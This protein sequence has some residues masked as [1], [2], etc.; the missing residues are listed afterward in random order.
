MVRRILTKNS[1]IWC[2]G[3]AEPT[4][5]IDQWAAV[6]EADTFLIWLSGM[7]GGP[8]LAENE[9]SATVRRDGPTDGGDRPDLRVRVISHRREDVFR[10]EGER[11]HSDGRRRGGSLES[12][13][14]EE[15]AL[16]V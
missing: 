4:S 8:E 3:E 7:T 10:R 16:R 15:G 11:I 13:V 1:L 6:Q 2:A 5:F 14:R 9:R 12:A